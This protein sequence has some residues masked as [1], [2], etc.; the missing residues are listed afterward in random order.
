MGDFTVRYADWKGGDFGNKDAGKAD[1][2]TFR[3]LNVCEYE[4]GLLGVRAGTRA[5]SV[6]GL[7]NHTIVPGPLA[8]WSRGTDVITV[9]GNR[10]YQFP[11]AGGAATAWSTYPSTPLGPVKFLTGG[12]VVY[13]LSNQVLYKHPNIATTTAITTPAPLSHVVRWGYYFVGIDANVPWRIWFSTVDAAGAHFDTWGANDFLDIGDTEAIRAMVP[14]FNTLYVGKTSG[15]NAVSGVLGT[16]A[17]VRGVITGNGPIDPRLTSLTTDSRIVYWPQGKS[18]AFFNGERVQIIDEHE[19]DF[20]RQT[21]PSDSVIVTPTE[22]RLL[23]AASSTSDALVYAYARN[24]WSRIKFSAP[25]GGFAP[26]DLRDGT[27]LPDDVV[28]GVVGPTTVGDPVQPFSYAHNLN[29]PGHQQD[30]WSAAVDVQDPSKL[31]TG[32]VTFPTYWEPIGR[33]VRCRSLIIQYRKWSSGVPS[34]L[35]QMR[36]RVDALGTYQGGNKIGQEQAWME[37]CE[38]AEDG[39][40]DDSWRVNFGDQGYGNGF[41][42]TFT[43][44]CGVALREVIA[45]CDVRTDRT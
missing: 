43:R 18:P 8:F 11:Q 41:R 2:D 23:L 9:I 5:V 15:W 7:P 44:L 20:T 1:A 13:S 21:A 27:Q 22:R 25:L 40:T 24:A 3:G 14:I 36:V 34:E 42:V 28:F 37:A 45:V 33:Q 26:G 35:N 38:R 19:L 4:S 31:V 39:G 29:R 30:R 32:E 16:L 12:G 10:P 6:T 17:S